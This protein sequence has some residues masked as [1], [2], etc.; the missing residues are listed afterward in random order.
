MALKTGCI[1]GVWIQ[2]PVK[3]VDLDWYNYENVTDRFS[4]NTNISYN[5]L[6][7]FVRFCCALADF[8]K[9]SCT[10]RTCLTTILLELDTC[11][12]S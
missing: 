11:F 2:C 6:I 9:C 10:S 3:T 1:G 7:D 8:C 12:V 4:S 5:N